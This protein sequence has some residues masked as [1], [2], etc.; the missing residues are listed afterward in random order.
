MGYIFLTMIAFLVIFAL[1]AVVADDITPIP[2]D[3]AQ[4]EAWF[5]ANVQP[6]S[7]RRGTLDPVLDAA[8]A[9]PQII[10]VRFYSS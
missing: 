10:K 8:E 5:K 7:A 9:S 1:P 2:E 3:K 6:Y 4:V